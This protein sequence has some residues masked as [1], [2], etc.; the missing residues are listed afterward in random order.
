MAGSRLPRFREALRNLALVVGSVS[1]AVLLLEAA[2][3]LFTDVPP[4]IRERDPVVGSRYRP[5]FR[6]RVFVEESGREVLL[7]FNRDGFRGR[8]VPYER[9]TDGRR[10]AVLGDSLVAAI[11]CD[12]ADTAVGHLE[13]LLNSSSPGHRWEVLNFGVSG[14]STGQELV[15]FREVVARYRPDIVIVAYFVGNDFSDNSTR[16]SSNPRIYFEIDRDG[17]LVQRPL[18][19]ARSALSTWLNAHSRLYVWQKTANDVLRERDDDG[20]RIFRSDPPPELD[21][22]WALNER[23]IVALRDEVEAAGSRFVLALYPSGAQVY[24]DIWEA[25]LDQAGDPPGTF[26]PTYPERR[27]TALGQRAAFPVVTMREPFLRAAGGAEARETRAGD[28]LFFGGNGHLSERG[29]A[30]AAQI[31]YRF[32]TT[33]APGQP[34]R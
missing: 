26:D 33:T 21:E 17:N 19:A 4:V 1:I 18:S 5:H 31:L 2:V 10:V 7:A 11:A 8:D 29:N 13:R 12:E 20:Y 16:L 22:V 6:G 34:S 14:S 27:L 30:L 3:R 23:L 15:L 25:L 32:L 9:T 24:G 28:L